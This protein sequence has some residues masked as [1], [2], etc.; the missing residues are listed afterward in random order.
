MRK[1]EVWLVELFEGA[2]REQYGL[3]PAIILA[4]TATDICIVIPLTSN[5]KALKFPYAV[6]VEP[7]KYNGL[8]VL[9]VA[10]VFQ[11]RAIDKS[12]LAKKLGQLEKS[13][14]VNILEILKK[15]LL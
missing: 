1:G 9:S 6:Q 13:L 4:D 14:L 10:L 3:R 15:L 2:G 12:R 8:R 5:L 11:I 7:S